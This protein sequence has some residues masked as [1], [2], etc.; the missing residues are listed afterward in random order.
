MMRTTNYSGIGNVVLQDLAIN[1]TQGPIYDR[2][3]EH[4]G[5]SDTAVISLRR[6]MLQAVRAFEAGQEP[7]GVDTDYASVRGV[8]LSM[9]TDLPWEEAHAEFD[10]QVAA[11][12]VPG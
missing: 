2:S 3:T 12:L 8:A 1:E 7:M 11:R 4:L 10:R 5:T 6:R 9:P